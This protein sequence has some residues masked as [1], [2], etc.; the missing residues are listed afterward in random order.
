MWN[1]RD[2][3]FHVLKSQET[4]YGGTTLYQLSKEIHDI[5]FGKGALLD[6][7]TIHAWY[8]AIEQEYQFDVRD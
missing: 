1:K 3:A 5:E 7:P 4:G 6:M 2:V 8:W